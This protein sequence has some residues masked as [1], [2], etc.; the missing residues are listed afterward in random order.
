M[1]SFSKIMMTTMVIV[2]L[3]SEASKRPTKSPRD[4]YLS[5]SIRGCAITKGPRVEVILG[6]VLPISRLSSPSR[7]IGME[8]EILL[9]HSSCAFQDSIYV[10]FT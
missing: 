9:F 6:R 5:P 10:V 4:A 1:L 7:K 3:L 8:V 2:S